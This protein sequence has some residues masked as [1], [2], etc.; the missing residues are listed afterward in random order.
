[1][2]TQSYFAY[3]LVISLI[4]ILSVNQSN[5]RRAHLPLIYVQ[6]TPSL[7]PSSSCTLPRFS[8]TTARFP[9]VWKQTLA[10]AHTDPPLCLPPRKTCMPIQSQ[11]IPN[12]LVRNCQSKSCVPLTS[13]GV[14]CGK[15]PTEDGR[16]SIMFDVVRSPC[17]IS[18]KCIFAISI[19]TITIS[20]SAPV[21]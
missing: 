2:I 7:V 18:A 3:V 4:F 13:C 8:Q 14:P 11:S 1:M 9:G 19:P 20:A 17:M 16:R 21:S 12:I 5:A 6:S 10:P 15:S